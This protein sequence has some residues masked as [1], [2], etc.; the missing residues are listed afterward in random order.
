MRIRSGLKSLAKVN[1]SLL[2][3]GGAYAYYAYPEL[4]RNPEQLVYATSRGFR[5]MY[6]VSRMGLDYLIAGD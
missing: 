4:R 3:G 2:V 1:G 6:T 5:L